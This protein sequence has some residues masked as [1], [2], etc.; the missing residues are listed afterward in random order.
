MI[1]IEKSE[2]E[3]QHSC[4]KLIEMLSKIDLSVN[5]SKTKYMV[6]IKT[7]SIPRN[8]KIKNYF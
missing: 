8:L 3:V 6:A 4:V 2:L 5:K 7:Y 1:L